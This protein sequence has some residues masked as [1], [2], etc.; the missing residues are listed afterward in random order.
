MTEPTLRDGE[1][2]ALELRIQAFFAAELDGAERDFRPPA[3]RDGRS[4]SRSARVGRS[5]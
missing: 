4:R 5:G 1:D 2:Q 3:L